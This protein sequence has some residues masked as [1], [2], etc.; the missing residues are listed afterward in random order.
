MPVDWPVSGTVP[1]AG[2]EFSSS[3]VMIVASILALLVADNK[4]ESVRERMLVDMQLTST[5]IICDIDITMLDKEA[6][7][8]NLPLAL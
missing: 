3:T 2:G 1:V 4:L 7:D 5:N 6:Y 8:V